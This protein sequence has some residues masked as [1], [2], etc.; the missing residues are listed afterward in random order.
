M[1]NKQGFVHVSAT[2][3]FIEKRGVLIV[4][5]HKAI[6]EKN[7]AKLRLRARRALNNLYSSPIGVTKKVKTKSKKIRE[8]SDNSRKINRRMR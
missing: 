7:L 8:I 1:K 3:K 6:S 4:E 2:A 5:E